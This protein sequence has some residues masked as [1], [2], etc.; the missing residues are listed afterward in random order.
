MRVLLFTLVL[1][2]TSALQARAQ[3]APERR[4]ASEYVQ[5]VRRGMEQLKDGDAV[6]AMA[7]LHEAVRAEPNL[8]AA[9]CQLGS[10]QRANGNVT[11]ALTSFQTCARLARQANDAVNEGRGLLGTAQILVLDRSQRDAA[12][13]AVAALR[14]FAD[15]HALVFAAPSAQALQ[16]ALDTIIELDAVS[17]EVRERREARAAQNES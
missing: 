17:A 15:T 1:A 6:G 2:S 12:R 11:D 14:N 10:A 7:T 16:Q 3:D 13:R 4:T 5:Q 8:P 9:H